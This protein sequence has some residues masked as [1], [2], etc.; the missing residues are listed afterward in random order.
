MSLLSAVATVLLVPPVNLVPF[1]LAGMLLARRWPA[2]GRRLTV[3]CLVALLLL[4]LPAVAVP[5]L[6]ALEQGL[7]LAAPGALAAPGET[8]GAIVILGGDAHAA[9]PQPDD[10]DVGVLSLERERA[11]AALARATHLPI[12]VTGG[13]VSLAG[14][15]VAL[16]MA[17]SL[18]VD[19]GC[20]VRWVEPA[21]A[22][23][24]QNAQFSAALL[25]RENIGT[26]L[27]VTHAWHMRRAL[28]AFRAAGLAVIPAPLPA[29]RMPRFVPADFVPRVSAWQYSYFALHEWLGCAWYAVLARLRQRP[30]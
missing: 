29:D 22:T 19:F 10:E 28:I 26:V 7:P 25:R 18:A 24:W 9:G 20:P 16:L 8:A 17:R 1:A 14:A 11:G 30:A 15:P 21:S 6:V 13:V 5:L 3:A 12:L 2:A 27:L 23:T 4:A